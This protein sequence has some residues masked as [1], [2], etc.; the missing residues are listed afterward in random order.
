MSEMLLGISSDYIYLYNR[1]PRLVS[2]FHKPY[3]LAFKSDNNEINNARSDLVSK[4]KKNNQN[5]NVFSKIEDIGEVEKYRSFW[6]F[7][8]TWDVFFFS[9]MVFIHLN[10]ISH[11]ISVH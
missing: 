7:D 2:D 4:W 1:E 8:K 9:I 5:D 10:M 11:I 6:D 3:F